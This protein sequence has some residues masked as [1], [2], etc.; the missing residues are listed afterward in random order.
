MYALLLPEKLDGFYSCGVFRS[1]FITGQCLINMKLRALQRGPQIHF[2]NDFD[3]ISLTSDTIS[4]HKLY[5]QEGNRVP[6]G[7]QQLVH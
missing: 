6:I 5:L 3:Q 4:L 7:S 2:S 1:L